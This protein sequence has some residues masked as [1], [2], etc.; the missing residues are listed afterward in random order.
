MLFLKH[1]LVKEHLIFFGKVKGLFGGKLYGAIKETMSEVG[2]SEKANVLSFALSG[3]MKRKLCLAMALI[4][5]PKFILLDEPVCI[6]FC[7][8]ILE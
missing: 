3:G 2:L 7:G 4:G 6:V 8:G 5:N 1:V